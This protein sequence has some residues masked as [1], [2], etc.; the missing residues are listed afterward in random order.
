MAGGGGGGNREIVC[1]AFK[2]NV[3]HTCE[4]CSRAAGRPWF[5]VLVHPS[6]TFLVLLSSN[7]YFGI[8][9]TIFIL[10]NDGR[11]E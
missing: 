2:R 4:G 3:P 9:Y 1:F 8:L 5:Q 7:L 6:F 10:Q 11:E